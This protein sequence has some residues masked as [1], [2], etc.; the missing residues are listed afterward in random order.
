MAGQRFVYQLTSGKSIT[1][2]IQQIEAFLREQEKMQSQRVP[3]SNPD[4]TVL[5][6]RVNGGNVKQLI[7]MDKALTIRFIGSNDGKV[8]IEF[9]EAK[10]V[11][12]GAVMLLSMFVL[13][14]LTITS[15]I[16]MYKQGRLPKK[17]R[18]VIN[19]Y[20]G[21]DNCVE[22]P[23]DLSIIAKIERASD[24]EIVHNMEEKF[25]KISNSSTMI[26]IANEA[27]KVLPRILSKII[28]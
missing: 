23:E 27:Q 4:Y 10:W 26:H 1:N 18:E 28:R 2:L 20:L 21:E 6:A 24:S 11:D 7:G 15:G 22:K 13:W 14:P 8:T 16:G 17:I 12:K 19:A 3:C 9:G 5:Q 25:N